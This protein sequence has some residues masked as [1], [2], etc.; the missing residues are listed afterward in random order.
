MKIK[1]VWFEYA[2]FNEDGYINGISEDAPEEMKEA[3]KRDK[4]IEEEMLD[5]FIR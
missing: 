4:K 5:N 2:T 3:Y 1:P